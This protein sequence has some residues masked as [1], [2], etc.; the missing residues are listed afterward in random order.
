M[1]CRGRSPMNYDG[2]Y[3]PVVTNMDKPRTLPPFL[4][5]SLSTGISQKSP[6]FLARISAIAKSA[7]QV[8]P[9]SSCRRCIPYKLP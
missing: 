5:N 3:T 1:N 6:R 7:S 2:Q 8:L 9:H 4:K